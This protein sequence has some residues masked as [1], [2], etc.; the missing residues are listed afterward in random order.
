MMTIRVLSFLACLIFSAMTLT[1][2]EPYYHSDFIFDPKVDDHGHVH[3]SAIVVC[4]DGAL[5]TV[6]YENGPD[7]P[8]DRF[9]TT[10]RDKHDNVR[11]GGSRKPA[12]AK[13]WEKPFVMNDTY[14]AADNNPTIVI[15]AEGKLWLFHST[16]L[17]APAWTWASSLL[18]FKISDDY[19][20]PGPPTWKKGGLLIPHP[21]GLDK[22][23]NSVEKT[24]NS[25]EG[26]KLYGEILPKAKEFVKELQERAKDPM[27]QRLGWMPRAHPL[28]RSDGTLI[29]PLSNEN[30]DIPMMAMTADDGETW[31]FSD[32][33]PGASMI[34]PSLV[35]LKDGT[36]QAYFRNGDP[37]QR[38]KRSLSRNGGMTWS[39]PEVTEL[40][41]L[42]G[43]LEAISLKNGNLLIVYNNH[44]GRARDR[45]AVSLSDDE[46]RTW[47]WT[48][49]LE[50]TP[51]GRFDYPS[52]IQTPDGKIHVSYSYNLET[53][54]HAEFNE[55]WVRAGD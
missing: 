35:E 31:T 13:E 16:M 28:I 12:G 55:A 38:I 3:A 47:K 5:R 50:D 23:L 33:V 51:N 40:P 11:V 8:S 49:Q 32:P 53:I 26:K 48:R 18:Q 9:Y 7:L 36:L 37:R 39:V 24:L 44:T 27:K 30:F 15:D 1:A 4:P 41:H 6:W 25:D 10:D 2:A 34:Q 46:G 54:K 42:G 17:G 21:L 29:L 45:L 14:G 22:V 20:K 52:V 43:G 19:Q